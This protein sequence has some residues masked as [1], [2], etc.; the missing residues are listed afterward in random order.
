MRFMKTV[1]SFLLLV[2]AID[3]AARTCGQTE[4]LVNV[5]SISEEDLTGASQ[6]IYASP[7]SLTLIPHTA[8][9]HTGKIWLRSAANGLHVWGKIGLS[10]AAAKIRNA[11]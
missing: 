5:P 8:Q 4:S 1:F 3:P 6:S 10:L 11:V 7:P 9:A 2:I